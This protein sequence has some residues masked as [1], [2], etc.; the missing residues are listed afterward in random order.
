M[1]VLEVLRVGWRRWYVAGP[2][3]IAT[4][5]LAFLVL[6]RAPSE[7]GAE[8]SMMMVGQDGDASS[9]L[10]EVLS[11]LAEDGTTRAEILTDAETD[12]SVT[13]L[14]SGILQVDA[15]A[16]KAQLAVGVVADVLDAMASIHAEHQ[17]TVTAAEASVFRTLR[18]PDRAT[19][20]GDGVFVAQGSARVESPA[21]STAAL[22]EE[23][24]R[25]L[26]VEVL[27][28]AEVR[29]AVRAETGQQEEVQYRVDTDR[30]TPVLR[31]SA[32]GEDPVAVTETVEAVMTQSQRQL[33]NLSALAG[34]EDTEARLEVLVAPVPQVRSN[35]V[36]KSILAVLAVGTAFAFGL[37]VLV[38]GWAQ[39]R[40]R[41]RAFAEPDQRLWSG[42]RVIREADE[43]P[44]VATVSHGEPAAPRR[45]RGASS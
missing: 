40:V 35:S 27:G 8:G 45:S 36:M 20:E 31:I 5:V 1:D 13:V 28:G 44:R 33:R 39:S 17:A 4:A 10:P 15:V 25:H 41:R 23:A 26:L 32:L 21:G 34:V 9:L 3:L 2:V 30:S 19:A 29:T 42:S 14:S 24:M 37:A 43:V 38:E 18:V 16:P 12:Y 7:Y 22:S 11:E 6:T